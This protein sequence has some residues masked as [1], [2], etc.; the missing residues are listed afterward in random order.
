MCS[1]Y[2]GHFK[3][4]KKLSCEGAP[5]HINFCFEIISW[6]GTCATQ[7]ALVLKKANRQTTVYYLI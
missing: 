3:V 1:G 4:F 7:D 2:S 6:K 5:T